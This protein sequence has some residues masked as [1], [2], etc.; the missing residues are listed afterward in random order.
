MVQGECKSHLH[1]HGVSGLELLSFILWRVPGY[2]G[3]E[4]NTSRFDMGK[5]RKRLG[6]H[7]RVSHTLH[8]N[9]VI[10]PCIVS[11]LLI[12]CRTFLWDHFS[13]LKGTTLWW[14]T[15]KLGYGELKVGRVHRRVW[16]LHNYINNIYFYIKSFPRV[17]MKSLISRSSPFHGT[18]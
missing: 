5:E 12:M 14:R 10:S 13:H 1:P 9:G 17:L 11:A 3:I 16:K 18:C 7:N 6:Y 15:G 4:W 2:G 8:F